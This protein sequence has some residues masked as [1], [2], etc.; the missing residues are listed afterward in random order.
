MGTSVPRSTMGKC[1][2]SEVYHTNPELGLYRVTPDAIRILHAESELHV[3]GILR[4]ALVGAMHE[5]RKTV[6]LRD[7][8]RTCD[9]IATS[10][11]VPDSILSFSEDAEDFME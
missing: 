7:F 8:Q 4:E 6:L 1:I 11:V 3:V 10:P 9:Q 5:D 2:R